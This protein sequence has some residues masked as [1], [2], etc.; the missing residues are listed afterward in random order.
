[1]RQAELWRR[2]AG[3][4]GVVG[5]GAPGR[6]FGRWLC[7]D[8][9]RDQHEPPFLPF[10]LPIHIREHRERFPRHA[11]A[12]WCWDH[13]M[14]EEIHRTGWRWVYDP[15]YVEP[16]DRTGETPVCTY[17]RVT[18]EY[19]DGRTVRL[20]LKEDP[21]TLVY[22][23]ACRMAEAT[24]RAKT[25]TP[26]DDLGHQ[27]LYCMAKVTRGRRLSARQVAKLQEKVYPPEPAADT[28]QESLP[29]VLVDT[30]NHP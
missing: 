22:C 11:F 27:E 15:L 19:P 14:V 5:Q 9:P 7:L 30:G 29:G 23:S 10:R 1:M 2:A 3:V 24:F 4:D 28:F 13:L 26:H 16:F 8:C 18:L 17:R 25:I 6:H 20:L 12:W 21:E